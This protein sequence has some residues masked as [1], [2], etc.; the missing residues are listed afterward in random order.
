MSLVS[1][2]NIIDVKVQV[3]DKEKD[4]PDIVL[5][6]STTIYANGFHRAIVAISFRPVDQSGN[7]ITSKV[8]LPEASA[9]QAN[10]ELID[11][12]KGNDLDEDPWKYETTVNHS[13]FACPINATSGSLINTTTNM[14][15]GLYTLYYY[16]HTYDQ[17][18]NKNLDNLTVNIGFRL[19]IGKIAPNFPSKT[20]TSKKGGDFDIL[21][22]V[23]LI[24]N[25]EL[26]FEGLNVVSVYSQD[27]P[28]GTTEL[29]PTSSDDGPDDSSDQLAESDLLRHV[30]LAY[31]FDLKDGDFPDFDHNNQVLHIGVSIGEGGYIY[32]QVENPTNEDPDNNRAKIT[33]PCCFLDE[34]DGLYCYKGYLWPINLVKMDQLY[35]PKPV[36]LEDKNKNTCSY[37]LF[38]DQFKNQVIKL[39]EVFSSKPSNTNYCP[40]YYDYNCVCISLY[41][42]FGF[43]GQYFGRRTKFNMKLIDQYGNS[44]IFY[45][46]PTNCPRI[47][48]VDDD[49]QIGIEKF[50]NISDYPV[51]WLS[52]NKNVTSL[53][54]SHVDNYF[55]IVTNN[56]EDSADKRQILYYN[57]NDN[58]II[59]HIGLQD[60]QDYKNIPVSENTE[61][62]FRTYRLAENNQETTNI[63]DFDYKLG[64]CADLEKKQKESSALGIPLITDS[65]GLAAVPIFPVDGNA[66]NCFTWQFWPVWSAGGFVMYGHNVTAGVGLGNVTLS[67][68]ED[69]SYDG[70]ALGELVADD[71]Y[72]VFA[73]LQAYEFGKGN[74]LQTLTPHTGPLDTGNGGPTVN[75]YQINTKNPQRGD[76][77]GVSTAFLRWQES[78]QQTRSIYGN[79]KNQATIILQ[80]DALCYGA[81]N[82]NFATKPI[83]STYIYNSLQLIDY[84]TGESLNDVDVSWH[85]SRDPNPF[86]V[87]MDNGFSGPA[88]PG[89]HTNIGSYHKTV[90]LYLTGN[91]THNNSVTRKIGIR[92]TITDPDWSSPIIIDIWKGY[93]ASEESA[94]SIIANLVPAPVVRKSD[95]NLQIV[96]K[97]SYT[98]TQPSDD[99]PEKTNGTPCSKDAFNRHWDFNISPPLNNNKRFMI[100]WRLA[101]D[102]QDHSNDPNYSN[103]MSPIHES[104]LSKGLY[105]NQYLLLPVGSFIDP[106]LNNLDLCPGGNFQILPLNRQLF[107]SQ[108]LVQNL[109]DGGLYIKIIASFS[110]V[111]QISKQFKPLNI[112]WI[113]IYGN[114]Y[115]FIINLNSLGML[116]TNQ[117]SENLSKNNYNDVLTP[118]KSITE[119]SDVEVNPSYNFYTSAEDQFIYC[120]N[121]T[122]S[123]SKGTCEVKYGASSANSEIVLGNP[124]TTNFDPSSQLG[125]MGGISNLGWYKVSLCFVNDI[126]RDA[127]LFLGADYD[128][129]KHGHY[130]T[131]DTFGG[132]MGNTGRFNCYLV[133]VWTDGKICFLGEYTGSYLSIIE[134]DSANGVFFYGYTTF[135]NFNIRS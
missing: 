73:T 90:K 51:D 84:E 83:D 5:S 108:K 77:C 39:S 135:S 87:V 65:Y 131:Y 27:I 59:D 118:G 132:V 42:T 36:A 9:V 133:P 105:H 125:S 114:V 47:F 98:L 30:H 79:G 82:N 120:D 70:Y 99:L 53:T 4:N 69:G 62:A 21:S 68:T 19:D 124:G 80:F 85:K 7:P 67:A 129:S 26:P 46:N 12:E 28:Q 22:T 91:I 8:N 64:I 23:K 55:W 48:S 31:Y 54:G 109:D 10:L 17:S 76:W 58:N 101:D 110:W 66:A 126:R 106:S 115:P 102:T 100:G 52:E 93:N 57:Y 40:E 128:T 35:L 61:F 6:N 38:A 104:T 116:Y 11:F 20:V 15:E 111:S 3:Y 81:T 88:L 92:F 103:P 18:K 25:I 29:T 86:N 89:V 50:Y 34:R 117:E 94:D 121:N 78:E 56:N 95:F 14:E 32:P 33:E 43:M 112:E 45:V 37:T 13:I 2:S 134:D 96:Y 130:I 49:E 127:P 107:M 123:E 24:G 41:V 122:W 71:S 119:I 113:D 74:G 75:P 97:G 16:V 44:L 1:W 60:K 72:S 63:E